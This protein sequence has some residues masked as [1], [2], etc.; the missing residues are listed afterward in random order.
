MKNKY[1][2][3]GRL[4][5]SLVAVLLFVA[6]LTATLCGMLPSITAN[7]ETAYSDV[8]DD[9]KADASF[10]QAQWPAED[11]K[12][13]LQLITVAESEHN[14]LFVYVYQP[15]KEKKT[16]CANY[17]RLSDT[18]DDEISPKDYSLTLLNSN[19]V[20][21][22]YKVEGYQ[23]K[24]DA[25]RY[26]VV[27]Q[28]MRPFIES[29]DRQAD[30]DNTINA[31]PFAVNRQYKFS[32][33]NGTTSISALDVETIVITDKLVGHVVH[34][35]DQFIQIKY[36]YMHFVAFKCDHDI[37]DLL[38]ADVAWVT[39]A[40]HKNSV[41]GYTYGT[42]QN[43]S[44]TLYAQNQHEI[45]YGFG[46]KQ[47]AQWNEIQSVSDFISSN[48]INS[49]YA[50]ALVNVHQAEK[51]TDEAKENLRNMDWVLQF[52]QVDETT[53]RQ[54][55]GPAAGLQTDHDGVNVT[56]VTILRLKFVT[57]GITYNLGVVDNK[58]TGSNKS[59][60][61]S[62]VIIT[63]AEGSGWLW[64]LIA[65]A[66]LVVL[67]IVLWP[68]MPY[69][70]KFLIWFVSL[71]FKAIGAT[72]KACKKREPQSPNAKGLAKIER[73]QARE[74]RRIERQAKRVNVEKLKN[75]IWS[76]KRESVKLTKAEDY[77]LQ[78][79]PEWVQ[80]EEDAWAAM[81]YF[82]DGDEDI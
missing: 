68:A 2:A 19:G 31:V 7:A 55:F 6:I 16:Y 1:I 47:V 27:I 80:A 18:I 28:L 64:T 75:D 39:Q 70:A 49:I 73:Q 5:Q 67:V 58:Q 52:Y 13:T 45:R 21:Y 65:I 12:H 17:I 26:Y 35:K 62:K 30:Y 66:L 77:A 36:T 25:V 57:N 43:Q 46:N 61:E 56:D 37:D 9:L 63:P 11:N 48:N 10:N 22:K 76:G 4:T 29:Y 32:T 79:D 34:E 82:G 78:H 42:P 8:L 20:F 41:L 24:Q 81:G 40:Y 23:V 38:E 71:P 14:E 53:M 3:S 69:I 54:I 33:I 60:N 72:V 74:R 50:T 59:S 44:V 15:A 51:L